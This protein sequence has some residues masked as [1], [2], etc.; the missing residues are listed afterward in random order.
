[1]DDYLAANSAITLND[2]LALA[3]DTV[4]PPENEDPIAP[5]YKVCKTRLEE[6]FGYLG[7]DNYVWDFRYNK[8]V[9]IPIFC[10]G[11]ASTYRYYNTSGKVQ[12]GPDEW[13]CDPD[14][15]TL[16]GRVLIPGG[17]R[18]VT[19]DNKV[20]LWQ[21]WG[22]EPLKG[23]LSLYF[24]LRDYVFM[25]QPEAAKRFDQWAGWGMAHPERHKQNT[26]FLVWG[27]HGIGKDLL[28]RAVGVCYGAHYLASVGDEQLNT[29]FNALFDGALFVHAEEPTNTNNRA[30]VNK[31]KKLIT[32]HKLPIEHKG[33]DSFLVDNLCNVYYTSNTA[34]GLYIERTERRFYVV[35]S[36]APEKSLPAK[37][38]KDYATW[39]DTKE[40]VAALLHYFIHEVDYA[41]YDPMAPAP[42]TDALRVAQESTMGDMSLRLQGILEG[43]CS[44]SDGCEGLKQGDAHRLEDISAHLPSDMQRKGDE[45]SLSNHLK[46]NFGAWNVGKVKVEGKSLRLWVVRNVARWR[47]CE[48]VQ[49]AAEY[50]KHHPW[51]SVKEFE[52]HLA[53]ARVVV[54]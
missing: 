17:A 29:R 18:P 11:A 6:R 16:E 33:F 48:K 34:N 2:L 3:V 42:E 36:L 26:A 14:R 38:A 4:D 1:M 45:T 8:P 22:A 51:D 27:K 23:D 32:G 53:N 21:G 9:K 49:I 47:K 43:N 46:E 40:G 24:A 19:T 52:Q 10:S 28:G 44:C 7:P 37:L 35:E 31:I 12:D 5:S 15:R 50:R 41:R 30:L 25:D 20:N 39:L 54:Q 13:L